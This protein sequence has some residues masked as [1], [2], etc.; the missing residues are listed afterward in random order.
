MTT[1]DQTIDDY[2]GTYT[3]V[4]GASGCNR[5]TPPPSADSE[6]CKS[7]H[8]EIAALRKKYENGATDM[9]QIDKD[10]RHFL[11]NPATESLLIPTTEIR[12]M[13]R[14]YLR[15]YFLP[16]EDCRVSPKEQDLLLLH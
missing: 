7:F 13:I 1:Y 6:I 10:L 15:G 5:S 3:S 4:E 2:D 9:D 14:F 8:K 11:E 16:K 12:C